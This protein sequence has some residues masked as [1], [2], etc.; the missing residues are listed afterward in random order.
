MTLTFDISE[1]LPFV[2][3]TEEQYNKALSI[4]ENLFFKENRTQYEEQ[5]L[6]V[7][8]VLIEMYENQVFSPGEASTPVSS[9]KFL[10]ESQGITQAD[11]VRKGV[12]SSGVVS[13]II[14]GKREISKQQIKKL[15][16]IF[17]VS[18][19]VFI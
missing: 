3:E 7:W 11:L 1:I 18:S 15:A 2:I 14:N 19:D 13:E 12:G 5:I 16:E 4:T 9:L 10:M 8:T 6:D 17:H